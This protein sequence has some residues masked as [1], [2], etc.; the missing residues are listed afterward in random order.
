LTPDAWY[1]TTVEQEG[2]KARRN[3][4]ATQM[5]VPK[6]TGIGVGL[7]LNFRT[8]TLRDGLRRVIS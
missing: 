3:W 1:Q 5:T 4:K 2:A 6:L 7:L 8:V